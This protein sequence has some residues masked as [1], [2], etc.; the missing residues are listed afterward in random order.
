[1]FTATISGETFPLK[2]KP[3]G[4]DVICTQQSFD[5]K[6]F[7]DNV[8]FEN[9]RHTNPDLAYCRNMKV[10]MRHSGASDG[11]ASH[12]LTNTKCI[13]CQNTS[14]AYFEKPSTS[15]QGWFGGC[16]ELDCTGSNNYLIHDQDGA[17]TGVESQILANNSMIGDYESS[18]TSIPE[19]NGHWCHTE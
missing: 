3:I 14:W 15:W 10:F 17:F 19:M 7:L 13:N 1:M 11:T 9:Y 4:H 12:Y 6:A 16:G 5:F 18:C 8:T 2:K